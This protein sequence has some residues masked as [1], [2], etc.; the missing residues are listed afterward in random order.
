MEISKAGRKFITYQT[1][2]LFWL[3][4]MCARVR[5][6]AR[7]KDTSNKLKGA[8]ENRKE[9]VGIEHFARPLMDG[10]FSDDA[11]VAKYSW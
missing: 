1:S 7:S 6:F 4:D 9:R 10:W 5:A 8:H 3:I 11:A 2:D